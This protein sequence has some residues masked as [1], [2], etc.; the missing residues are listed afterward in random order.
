MTKPGNTPSYT[1]AGYCP[2]FRFEKPSIAWT[3]NHGKFRAI[4][5]VTVW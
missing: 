3:L 2:R 4:G 1:V 5:L